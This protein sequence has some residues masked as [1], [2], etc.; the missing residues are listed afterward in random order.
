MTHNTLL[1]LRALMAAPGREMYGLEIMRGLTLKSGTMYPLLDRAEASGWVT[2]RREDVSPQAEGRPRRRYYRI[3]AEG[4]KAAGEAM[5]R[6]ASRLAAL[7]I[8]EVPVESTAPLNIGGIEIGVTVDERQPPGV[9]SV[10]ASGEEVTQVRSFALAD[11]AADC[12]HPKARVIKGFCYACGRSVAL[13]WPSGFPAPASDASPA[14]GAPA[15]E[16]KFMG[17]PTPE[18]CRG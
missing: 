13:R 17:G 14:R 7:G 8:T 3:T 12:P 11:E 6:E 18:P 2:V 5:E 4:V 16:P 15:A 9:V 1:V 10:I